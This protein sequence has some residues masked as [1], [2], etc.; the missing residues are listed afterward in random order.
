M[1]HETHAHSGHPGGNRDSAR[2]GEPLVRDEVCGMEFSAAEAA[3]TA[4]FQGE[5]YYFCSDR[6]RGRFLEHPGWYVPIA[7]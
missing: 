3:A 4:G 5:T 6:C 7:E 1:N 2:A